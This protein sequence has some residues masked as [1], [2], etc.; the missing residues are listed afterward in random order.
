MPSSLY[1]DR[2]DLITVCPHFSSFFL[3]ATRWI[4]PS[5]P[6]IG[7]VTAEGGISFL[8]LKKKVKEKRKFIEKK[9]S[10]RKRNL[11]SFQWLLQLNQ[12]ACFV[13]RKRYSFINA[14]PTFW[15]NIQQRC[16]CHITKVSAWSRIWCQK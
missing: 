11:V 3:P 14:R 13:L 4:V 9:P 1:S 16:P 6:N 8:T 7:L 5:I 2:V 15:Q 10:N 12:C